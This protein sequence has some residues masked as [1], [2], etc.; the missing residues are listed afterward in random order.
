MKK[1]EKERENR[2]CFLPEENNPYPLCI[3][4]K[5]KVCEDLGLIFYM[6]GSEPLC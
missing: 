5:R 6:E 3:G 1:F 4:R 2:S